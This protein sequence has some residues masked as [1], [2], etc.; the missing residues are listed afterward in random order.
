MS[1]LGVFRVKRVDF[2]GKVVG[3]LCQNNNGPCPLLAI[4]NCLLLQREIS[5]HSDI[6]I[7]E[8]EELVS[9]VAN[10]VL[11]SNAGGAVDKLSDEERVNLQANVQ[12]VIGLLPSLE[13]G[14][15]VNVRFDGIRSLEPVAVPRNT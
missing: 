10:Y 11:T 3:I 1:G 7:I 13:R 4:A 8:L 6:A 15:D 12:A 5:I 14:L 9:L 2:L